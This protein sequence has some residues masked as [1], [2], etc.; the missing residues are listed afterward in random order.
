MLQGG[1]KIFNIKV[2]GVEIK[3]LKSEANFIPPP[4]A[5]HFFQELIHEK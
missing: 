1:Y 3:K 4:S 5:Q 2:I